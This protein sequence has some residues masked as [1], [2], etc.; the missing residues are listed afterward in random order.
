[1]ECLPFV[2]RLAIIRQ[3]LVPD[4]PSDQHRNAFSKH[5][6]RHDPWQQNTTRD[7][8]NKIGKQGEKGKSE[9]ERGLWG[10]GE[11]EGEDEGDS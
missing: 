9:G 2:R 1:M 4:S 11:G 5:R 3:G 7:S 6:R 10:E 8:P